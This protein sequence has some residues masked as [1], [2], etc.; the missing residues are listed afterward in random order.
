MITLSV[1]KRINLTCVLKVEAAY[2]SPK[3]IAMYSNLGVTPNRLYIISKALKAKY[4]ASA[5][6]LKDGYASHLASLKS[7]NTESRQASG[8]ARLFLRRT[9]FSIRQNSMLDHRDG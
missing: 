7:P 3:D 8:N 2:G 1:I 6:L 4:M 5:T 9:T